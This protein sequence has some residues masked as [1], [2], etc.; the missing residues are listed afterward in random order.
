[1]NP[2]DDFLHAH[3]VVAMMS[4]SS[5]ATLAPAGQTPSIWLFVCIACL[6]LAGLIVLYYAMGVPSRRRAA[7]RAHIEKV[8]YGLSVVQVV[9]KGWSDGCDWSVLYSDGSSV[10]ITDDY[11]QPVWTIGMEYTRG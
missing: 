6:V 11:R 4:D 5:N 8:R 9:R 3:R 2:T 10:E 1:M 7:L